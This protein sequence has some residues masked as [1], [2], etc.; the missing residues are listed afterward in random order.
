MATD[1]VAWRRF[2]QH[3]VILVAFTR[4]G[5]APLFSGLGAGLPPGFRYFPS[6]ATTR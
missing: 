3:S 6:R 2:C 1:G 4:V 5:G